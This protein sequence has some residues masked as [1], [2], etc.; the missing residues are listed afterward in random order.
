[1]L[2]YWKVDGL[3][4]EDL[5]PTSETKEGDNSEFDSSKSHLQKVHSGK[6]F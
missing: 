1:M 4:P 2:T 3:G 6:K 5:L